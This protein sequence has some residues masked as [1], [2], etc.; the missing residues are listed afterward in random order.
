MDNRSPTRATAPVADE[1][2]VALTK[3]LIGDA[4]IA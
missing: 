2:D 3:E 1:V 4:V